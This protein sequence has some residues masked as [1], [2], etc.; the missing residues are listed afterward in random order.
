M[1]AYISQMLKSSAC[2]TLRH[3]RWAKGLTIHQLAEKAGVSP[4]L[5]VKIEKGGQPSQ[6]Q[7]VYAIAAE[8]GLTAADLFDEQ[9]VAS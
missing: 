3:A 1:Y 9:E 7:K 4:N 8:L 5:I 6:G 2:D